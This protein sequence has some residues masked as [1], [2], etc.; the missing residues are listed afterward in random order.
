MKCERTKPR[1]ALIL[2]AMA[3]SFLP[4][5][6]SAKADEALRQKIGQTLKD[7]KITGAVWATV[8]PDGAISI[9]AA[10]LKNAASGEVMSTRHRVHVGSVTKTLLAVGV[11][12]LVTEKRLALDAPVEEVLSGIKFENP[13][14]SH[15]VRIRHLLDHTSGLENL[16]VW[17]MFSEQADPAT[18]LEVAFRK[19]PSVLR[20]RTIPGSRFSYSNM[21]YTLLGMVVEAVTKE[22]YETYLDQNLLRPL[23]M[24]HSTFSFVTQAGENAD[25]DL[26]MGHL[27]NASP[28]EAV[29]IYLRPAGQFTTTAHDMGLFL[30]FLMSDGGLNGQAFIDPSLL[31]A[32]F[33]PVGTE[34]INAGLD[35]GYSLGLMKRDRHN[36]VGYAHSGNIIGYR[37]MIYVFPREQ[38]A[39][40]I[41]H[42]MDS[43]TA[44]YERFNKILIE[45]LGVNKIEPTPSG[46][47][48][49]DVADW[50]GTYIRTSFQIELTSYFDVLTTFVRVARKEDQL[51]FKPFQKAEVLL[52]P[53]GGR[54]FRAGDRV[55]ASHVLYRDQQNSPLITDGFVTYE[56]AN[57]FHL[58]FLWISLIF[59]CLGLLFI[60]L[61]GFIRS[62]R[63]RKAFIKEPLSVPFLSV[64]CLFI[65]V[66]FF[67]S[68]SFMALGDLTAASLLTATVTG[69]LPPAMLFGCWKYFKNGVPG[70]MKKVELLGVISV[71]QWITVL[72]FWGMIPFRLWV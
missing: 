10:G 20:L 25:P 70:R 47:M 11:L 28:Q 24:N 48:P 42:N 32:M 31:S 22:S 6:V 23:G 61:A 15:P 63:R 67:V 36:V 26:A 29:P 34:A 49:E 56:R 14:P 21:G 12:R 5:P 54:S 57:I 62:V 2:C 19:D 17:Q 44:Q 43:E 45:A 4:H 51:M 33:K 40:F 53:A 18:P 52:T 60:L 68:Q 35:V 64:C 37:A 27:D 58:L 3:I 46:S 9:G 65:P 1:S 41:S 13:W 71:L 69:L 66:P 50:D 16:R 72:S 8:D 59:G 30:R 39:F 7:E 38:K 55:A